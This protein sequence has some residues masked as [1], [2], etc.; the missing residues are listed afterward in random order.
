[1][2]EIVAAPSRGARLQGSGP[3][4]DSRRRL[5]T[6]RQLAD[7]HPGAARLGAALDPNPGPPCVRGSNVAAL[8][9]LW[10]RLPTGR[11]EPLRPRP[12]RSWVPVSLA[13]QR[14]GFLIASTTARGHTTIRSA[15]T[16]GRYRGGG[17]ER[18][19]RDV[20]AR[21][22]RCARLP[23]G[24]GQRLPGIL[25]IDEARFELARTVASAGLPRALSSWPV[26]TSM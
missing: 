12:A 14:C 24:G 26:G 1:V 21:H 4:S 22:D 10:N 6:R 17:A 15:V 8:A 11:P 3:R 5:R 2:Q 25:H 20:L 16:A 9:G 19:H 13:Q 23:E 7:R 18:R